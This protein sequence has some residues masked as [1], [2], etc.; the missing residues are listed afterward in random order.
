LV[1]PKIIRDWRHAAA[2]IE[3]VVIARRDRDFAAL[4]VLDSFPKPTSERHPPG[5]QR[6]RILGF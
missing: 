5:W 6:S 2:V 3:P 4:V 1:K